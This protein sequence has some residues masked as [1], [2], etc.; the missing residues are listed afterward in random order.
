MSSG[1]PRNG[2]YL[3][4]LGIVVDGI[5]V[6]YDVSVTVP[7]EPESRITCVTVDL[8]RPPVLRC[9]RILSG[10]DVWYT[11][12][13]GDRTTRIDPFR[14]TKSEDHVTGTGKDV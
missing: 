3:G 10:L 6:I 7:T 9:K 8:R 4:T 2:Q 13:D 14:V 11:I 5:G 12:E 1:T